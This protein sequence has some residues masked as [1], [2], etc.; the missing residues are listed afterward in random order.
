MLGASH[1]PQT[2]DGLLGAIL[3]ALTNRQPQAIGT[4]TSVPLTASTGNSPVQIRAIGEQG[5]VEA[6]H[7]NLQQI[8]GGG[9]QGTVQ[10]SL[11]D[12]R[13][14]GRVLWSAGTLVKSAQN[15][16]FAPIVQLSNLHIPYQDGLY[17]VVVVGGTAP[18][19]GTADV[20]V[21]VRT[22]AQVR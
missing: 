2:T 11:I 9:A 21:Y 6:F 14:N 3:R 15:L 20:N 10:L 8:T 5:Y 13:G 17:F 22:G 16:T 1:L 18:A 4:A 7:I 19:S 12:G